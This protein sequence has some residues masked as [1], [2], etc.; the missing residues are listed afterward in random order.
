[1]GRCIANVC[2]AF[3]QS[4][5]EVESIKPVGSGFLYTG[6]YSLFS[7]EDLE[8]MHKRTTE[9]L[10][11]HGYIAIKV[12]LT[13]AHAKLVVPAMEAILLMLEESSIILHDI[14]L[15]RDCH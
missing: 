1:L 8:K 4:P 2:S 15:T 11:G 7:S 14:D 9:G 5:L 3:N 6:N 10:Y 13:D 12:S